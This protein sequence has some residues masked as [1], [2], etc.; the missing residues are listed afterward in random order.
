M[1]GVDTISKHLFNQMDC[2]ILSCIMLARFFGFNFS[3]GGWGV[4]GNTLKSDTI[5][6][7]TTPLYSH[8]QLPDTVNKNYTKALQKL[9][10]LSFPVRL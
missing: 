4:N 6:S 7:T 10:F 3:G 8:Q 5:Q 1:Q 2:I 9:R